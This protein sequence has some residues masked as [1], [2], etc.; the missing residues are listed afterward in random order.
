MHHP[1]AYL[2]HAPIRIAA[3]KCHKQGVRGGSRL[4]AYSRCCSLLLSVRD[5]LSAVYVTVMVHAPTRMAVTM[6]HNQGPRSVGR[7]QA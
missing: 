6:N 4:Q 1:S 7:L 3:T 2:V 5:D